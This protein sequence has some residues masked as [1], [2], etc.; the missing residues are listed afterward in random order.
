VREG[1]NLTGWMT[2]QVFY[3]YSGHVFAPKLGQ[4]N[5]IYVRALINTAY[6]KTKKH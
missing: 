2:A 5:V 3:E 6:N 4:I 1:N